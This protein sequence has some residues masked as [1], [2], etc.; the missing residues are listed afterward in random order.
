MVI[1]A[2]FPNVENYLKFDFLPLSAQLQTPGGQLQAASGCGDVFISRNATD[3]H[4]YRH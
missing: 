4:E 2:K 3:E 1:P